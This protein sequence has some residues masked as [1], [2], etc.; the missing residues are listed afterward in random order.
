MYQ[1]KVTLIFPPDHRQTGT[2]KSHLS[3]GFG[4]FIAVDGQDDL[5]FSTP[6]G[7]QDSLPLIGTKVS[8]IIV[9]AFD[10]KKNKASTRAEKVR[11]E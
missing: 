2:V 11:K 1:F 5:Y 9:Q 4:G 7:S 10:K 3:N 8:F 6:R